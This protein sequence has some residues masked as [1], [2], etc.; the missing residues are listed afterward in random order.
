[1]NISSSSFN[2]SMMQQVQQSQRTTPPSATQLSSKVMEINDLNS[3]SL[4][5]IDEVKLSDETFSFIDED[6]DG[7]LSSSE[8]ETSFSS[9]LESMK[10]QTTSP[11]E[12][13]ELLTSMGLDVPPPPS[14]MR[15]GANAQEMASDIFSKND[16]NE[17]GLL[18]IDELG[19]EEELFSSLDSD[20]DGNITQEELTSGLNTLLDSVKNGEKS[21]EEI[22]DVLTSLGVEP[23]ENGRPDGQ[24]PP[25]PPGGGGDATSSEEYE[26]A[27]INED[28]I[29][30]AAEQAEYD[31]TTSDDMKDYTMKLVSTLLDALKNEDDS[32]NSMDLSKY[33]SIMSMV[34]NELQDSATAKKI[35]SYVSNLDLGLKTA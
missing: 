9:M 31:G 12:F 8:L 14:N 13:G 24:G 25:P 5:S 32:S 6:S 7:S 34:N 22:G 23:P 28:G 4:L 18:S 35:N 19:I 15:G 11:E 30:T 3:D 17:D 1:M 20:G 27:D 33:K 26:E 10:N 16:S 29:V 21:K 2:S